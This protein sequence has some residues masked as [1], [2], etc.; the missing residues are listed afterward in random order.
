MDKEIGL[1]LK[2]DKIKTPILSTLI[3]RYGIEKIFNCKEFINNHR[4]YIMFISAQDYKLYETV[5]KK[6]KLFIYSFITYLS[7][8]LV[9][10]FVSTIIDIDQYKNISECRV[11]SLWK[12]VYNITPIDINYKYITKLDIK[13]NLNVKKERRKYDYN[14]VVKILIFTW[15]C[16]YDLG[17]YI[18]F[19]DSDDQEEINKKEILDFID[20]QY[21]IYHYVNESKEN[22]PLFESSSETKDAFYNLPNIIDIDMDPGY[23]WKLPGIFSKLP[24]KGVCSDIVDLF[25]SILYG[26]LSN[27]FV[28]NNIVA[29]TYL[30]GYG[31][32]D[33]ILL[34]ELF[35]ITLDIPVKI[36][37]LISDL[38][39]FKNYEAI[40]YIKE[41]ESLNA[42]LQGQLNLDNFLELPNELLKIIAKKPFEPKGYFTNFD[43]NINEFNFD[44]N[45]FKILLQTHPICDSIVDIN[46]KM[47]IYVDEI[48]SEF[49]IKIY[50]T[51]NYLNSNGNFEMI[52]DYEFTVE[53]E[54]NSDNIKYFN[55]PL[56]RKEI[57]NILFNDY[58][59][60][61]Q[62]TPNLR[63]QY[64]N[65]ILK[66]S[67]LYNIYKCL[68]NS[69]IEN[70]VNALINKNIYLK[71][72][73][74]C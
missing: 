68:V 45:L 26:Y 33:P 60:I 3:K 57:N 69:D 54:I 23:L 32:V 53:N 52:K 61:P 64:N 24:K 41:N 66:K 10:D 6:Y 43:V 38:Y 59:F 8:T 62:N 4:F 65:F 37:G 31:K 16:K 1:I 14:D 12:F 71:T 39:I 35:S 28:T 36:C 58:H 30:F 15:K 56:I 72:I 48:Y 22:Y 18:L 63:E 11:L 51:F 74:K 47:N 55:K 9:Q 67:N 46:N 70:N 2:S 29:W 73:F 27:G 5:G 44:S 17:K 19:K 21:S 7:D 50:N 34:N 42:Y 49:S 20:N 25:F 13:K 40:D